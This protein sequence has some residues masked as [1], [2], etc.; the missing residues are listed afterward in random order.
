MLWQLQGKKSLSEYSNERTNKQRHDQTNKLTNK[1]RPIQTDMK[2]HNIFYKEGSPTELHHRT[3][4][5]GQTGQLTGNG[6][7]GHQDQQ[8]D[9]VTRHVCW[10]KDNVYL[11]ICD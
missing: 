10:R 2:T 5:N 11:H 6:R 4:R 3:L 9:A 7:Y 1:Q 8:H